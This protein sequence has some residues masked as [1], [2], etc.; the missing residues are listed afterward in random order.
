MRK[1]T[2]WT[3]SR[4]T[5]KQNNNI[6]QWSPSWVLHYQPQQSRCTYPPSLCPPDLSLWCDPEGMIQIMLSK[7]KGQEGRKHSDA[8]VVTQKQKT[9]RIYRLGAERHHRKRALWRSSSQVIWIFNRVMHRVGLQWNV[10]E[11]QQNKVVKG[12]HPPFHAIPSLSFSPLHLPLLLPAPRAWPPVRQARADNIYN[13][14]IILFWTV[15]SENRNI[16]KAISC[17][18]LQFFNPLLSLGNCKGYKTNNSEWCLLVD[19]CCILTRLI[20]YLALFGL[21]GFISWGE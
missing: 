7:I 9:T 18:A 20:L 2:K 14:H 3:Q 15:S 5:N 4:K 12:L 1:D 19:I 6:P 16:A 13:G 21:N 17:P 11:V 8:D 10:M